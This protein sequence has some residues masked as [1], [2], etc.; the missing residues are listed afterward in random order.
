MPEA[1]G[2]VVAARDASVEVIRATPPAMTVRADGDEDTRPVLFG[3]FARFNQW[4]EIDSYFEGRFMERI[5]PG[6]FRKT[7]RERGDDIR[8]LFQHGRDPQVGDKPIAEIE[9]LREDPT[10]GAYYEA[11]LLD[12]VPDL[13]LSGLRAGQYGQ[14]FRMQILR[15]EW[16]EEPGAS[17]HNPAGLP[18]RTIKEIRLHE[19][20]PVTFPAYANTEAGVRSL[21]DTFVFEWLAREPQ[22]ARELV[23][24]TDLSRVALRA[25]E[26][27]DKQ[28][29]PS[30]T[31]AASHRTSAPERRD[32]PSTGRFGLDNT[33]QRPPWAL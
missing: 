6:A 22:R 18:E 31:D 29:A 17:D 15:E 13:L 30:T 7:F 27:Q 16:K 2:A 3:Y 5:A 8:V 28:D 32:T 20:G 11:R 19:F 9:E 21:T 33:S 24:A 25:T 10:E 26:T 14:S 1:N 23:G 12:G 4:T